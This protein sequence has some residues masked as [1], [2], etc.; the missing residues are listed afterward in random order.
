M[1]LNGKVA[2]V[3]GGASGLGQ[4]TVEAYDRGSAGMAEVAAGQTVGACREEIRRI[5]KRLGLAVI[6]Q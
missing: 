4:G 1:D 3:T 5:E 2:I 6:T